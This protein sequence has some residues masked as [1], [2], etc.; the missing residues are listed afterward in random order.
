MQVSALINTM[1]REAE[2]VLKSFTLA[3]GDDS[4]IGVILAK[5]DEHFVLKRNIIHERARF[6]KGIKTKERW[7]NRSYEA[8]MNQ[9]NTVILEPVGVSTYG[10]GL[11]LES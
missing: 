11:S 2:H 6:H 5:V 8:F 4:K 9:L 7:S 10:I 3:E 1:G